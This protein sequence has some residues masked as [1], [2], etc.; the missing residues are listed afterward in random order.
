MEKYRVGIAGEREDDRLEIDAKSPE[1]AAKLWARRYDRSASYF[2]ASGGTE[3]VEVF[4]T[5]GQRSV[6][7]V[8][9]SVYEAE[10]VTNAAGERGGLSEGRNEHFSRV[11]C[12]AECDGVITI[13]LATD[14][15]GRVVSKAY[16]VHSA[17]EAHWTRKGEG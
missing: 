11:L 6:F 2:L 17:L 12:V 16:E 5:D 9:G 7:A 15:H 10:P 4:A 3:L 13:T 8:C 1:R 14:E